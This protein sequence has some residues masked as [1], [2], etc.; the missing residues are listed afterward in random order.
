MRNILALLGILCIV[1]CGGPLFKAEITQK[2]PY[3]SVGN[4]Y[5]YYNLIQ[6]GVVRCDTI[7]VTGI[8]GQCV[9]FCHKNE[10]Y[11]TS[12]KRLKYSTDKIE[13]P[14]KK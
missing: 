3:I 2:I 10:N 1:G 13:N 6:H 5:I 9:Y 4:K 8:D 7:E 12:K 14:P 11:I